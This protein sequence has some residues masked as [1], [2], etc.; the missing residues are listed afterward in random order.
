MFWFGRPPVLKWLAAAVLVVG[1]VAVEFWPSSMVPVPYAAS[2][3][4]AG[5]PLDVTW[6]MVPSGLIS[7]PALTGMVASHDLK[8]GEPITISDVRPPVEVPSG[9][10]ALAV[11]VPVPL[12]PGSEIRLV[13]G[14]GGGSVPGLVMA[15]SDTER[16]DVSGPTALVAVPGDDAGRV[17]SAVAARQVVVLVAP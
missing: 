13:I 8:P 14:E 4:A 12:A 7:A 9:W 17:A 10:W 11:E 16:F 3:T 2:E 6:R 15:N 5:D 1:A